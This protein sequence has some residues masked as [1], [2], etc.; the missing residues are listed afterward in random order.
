MSL[1]NLLCLY[2]ILFISWPLAAAPLKTSDKY[3]DPS[4][5]E[6]TILNFEA[7]D[8]KVFPPSEAI[9]VTGSSSIMLWHNNIHQDLAPL[10]IIARGF[11]GSTTYDLL[12][13]SNRIITAYT[14][15]AV[16]IY[17]GE[18]DIDRGITPEDVLLTFKML[19]SALRKKNPSLRIYLISSKLSPARAKHTNDFLKLNHYL[20]LLAQQDKL[21]TFIDIT[22]PMLN[23]KG[24]IRPELFIAD[25][26]HMNTQGYEIWKNII[27]PIVNA[28]ELQYEKTL[29][30]SFN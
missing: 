20:S 15:R 18:N 13:F 11:G 21:I 16:V 26:L 22:Q 10:T 7:S 8:K 12:Y 29:L 6:K 3:P 19:I 1:S 27:R 5:F 24:Q 4:R 9:V 28:I 17:E 23:K 2:F 14:P 25:N 30:P